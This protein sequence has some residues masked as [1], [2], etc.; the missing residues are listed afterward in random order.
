[1]TSVLVLNAPTL[2]LLGPRRPE[3]YGHTTLADVAELCRAEA[4]RLG[5][6]L[7]VARAAEGLYARAEQDG[8]YDEDF[9]AVM[10]SVG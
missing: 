6:A 9:A 4:G 5:R 8:R 7:P 3:V 2:N 10:E 1:M